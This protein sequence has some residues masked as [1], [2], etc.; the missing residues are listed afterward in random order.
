MI[1]A[2]NTGTLALFIIASIVAGVG[3]GI[4]FSAA[5]RGLLYGGKLA[6][7]APVFSAIYLICYSGATSLSLISGKLSSIYS[8]PQI[9]LGYGGLTLVATMVTVIWARNT[10]AEVASDGATL[11]D[12]IGSIG[13]QA[14]TAHSGGAK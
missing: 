3:Q 5:T 12:P 7:R 14:Q 8:L 1:I 10:H 4:A 6:D 2:V 13:G 9:A 11:F